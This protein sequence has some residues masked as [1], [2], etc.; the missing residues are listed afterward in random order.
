[1]PVR[2]SQSLIEFYAHDHACYKKRALGPG[3]RHSQDT[4]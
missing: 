3:G 4:T 2:N 1:M